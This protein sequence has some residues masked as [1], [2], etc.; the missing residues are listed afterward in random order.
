MAKQLSTLE[1]LIDHAV[2]IAADPGR[3]RSVLWLDVLRNLTR[4][5]SAT[6]GFAVLARHY[7]AAATADELARLPVTG[8]YLKRADA[9]ADLAYGRMQAI[10]MQPVALDVAQA[11]AA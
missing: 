11:E 2:S 4:R 5:C 7:C 6:E 1:Q 3:G 8:P 10:L 9:I